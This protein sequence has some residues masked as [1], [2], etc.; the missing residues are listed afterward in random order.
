MSRYYSLEHNPD[1]IPPNDSIHCPTYWC[2]MRVAS[3]N[4][5]ISVSQLRGIGLFSSVINVRVSDT[6]RNL[7]N[8]FGT[9]V[10]RTYCR[11]CEKMIGWK[12]IAVQEPHMYIIEGRFCMRLYKLTFS[13]FVPMIRSI[14]EQNFQ[15]NE[16]NADQDADTTDED[17]DS[18]DPDFS[19]N[20]KNAD[21]DAD[22]TE[23][24]GDSDDPD[25]S[26]NEQNADQ[27]L[28]ANEQNADQDLV[29]NEQNAD[30]DG[31]ANDQVPNE[32]EVGAN[33]QNVDQDRDS[34][35]EYDYAI[36]TYLMYTLGEN[37]DQDGGTNE[38]NVDQHGVANEQNA[39]Q[40]GGGNEQN[41]DQ[42]GGPPMKR[43]KT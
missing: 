30:Q 36:S 40:H 7:Q 18:D 22:T 3:F 38:Q 1:V 9:T 4:D 16:E 14:Q 31:D 11:R 43:M 6:V 29:T 12:I 42:D 21:Q 33:E 5:Y 15:A 8:H 19:T 39:V 2:G 10:A 26:A 20:E 25:F 28:G 27:Y 24:D 37:D 35:E 17:G 34:D 41:H 13:N 32:Q 23:G